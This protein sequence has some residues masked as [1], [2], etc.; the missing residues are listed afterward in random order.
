MQIPSAITRFAKDEDGT[1]LVIWGIG[2]A[3]FLGLIA[4][5]FDLGAWASP[6]RTCNPTPTARRWPPPANWTGPA[7]DHQCDQCRRGHRRPADLRPRRQ[8]PEQRRHHADLPDE[9]SPERRHGHRR[10]RHRRSHPG[11]FRARGHRRAYGGPDLRG[12]VPDVPGQQRRCDRRDGQ[13]H[14]R[15]H[16][17]GLRRVDDDDV[18]A[19]GLQRGGAKRPGDP[20]ARGRTRRRLVGAGEFRLPPARGYT[21]GR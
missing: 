11:A 6:R 18:P 14:R 12:R 7:R 1:F 15:Q 2:L 13:R 10:F 4:L 20:A 8:G 16:H 3:V 17:A 9:P 21:F 19:A 5:S